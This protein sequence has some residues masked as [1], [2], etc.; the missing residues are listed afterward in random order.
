MRPRG[1]KSCGTKTELED[2]IKMTA[3]IE[4]DEPIFTNILYLRAAA[5]FRMHAIDDAVTQLSGIIRKKSGRPLDMMHQ[6]RYLRARAFEQQQNTKMAE[7]DYRLYE[8]GLLDIYKKASYYLPELDSTNKKDLIV[9]DILTHQAG[10]IPFIPFWVQTVKDSVLMPEYYSHERSEAYPLQIAP[11][12]FGIKSLPDS[13]WLWS[14][15]SRLARKAHAHA[16]QLRLQR[17]RLIHHASY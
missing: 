13:L 5:L 3:L 15:N 7:K 6:I 11:T 8:K 17:H 2:V 12:V 10:L 9:K 14:I 1:G 16:L 4:N